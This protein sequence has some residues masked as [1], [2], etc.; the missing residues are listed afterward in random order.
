MVAGPFGTGAEMIVPISVSTFQSLFAL[1]LNL[2]TEVSSPLV[3]SV[4]LENEGTV[5]GPDSS[6][7]STKTGTPKLICAWAKQSPVTITVTVVSSFFMP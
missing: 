6:S 5:M 2:T 3:S 1:I 4:P 7:I